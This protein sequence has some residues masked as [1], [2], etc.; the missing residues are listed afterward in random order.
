MSNDPMSG[1]E[2]GEQDEEDNPGNHKIAQM[3][4]PVFTESC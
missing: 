2:Q 3:N 1:Q 4:R